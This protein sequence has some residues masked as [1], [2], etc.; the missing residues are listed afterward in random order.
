MEEISQRFPRFRTRPLFNDEADPLVGWSKPLQWRADVTYA[1]MVVKVGGAPGVPVIGW[2]PTEPR[3]LTA[4]APSGL[5]GD[6]AAPGP[7]AVGPQ[8]H[9]QLQ[10]AEQRQRLPQLPP[11]PLQPAHPDRPLPGQQH[12]AS[13]RPA[14][15]QARPR[16]HGAAGAAGWVEPAPP[17]HPVVGSSLTPVPLWWCRPPQARLR[18]LLGST[19]R[20]GAAALWE[21]WP[22]AT[23][24]RWRAA[25]APTAGRQQR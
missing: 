8:Q 5:P 6:P 24:W 16:R 21:L 22:A 10:A 15:G 12:P 13:P 4:V 1:A 2:I 19:V 17:L 25:A 11:P 14:A 3:P 9:G 18:W 7:A 20:W 23:R